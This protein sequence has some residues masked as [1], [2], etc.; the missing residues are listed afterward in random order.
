MSTGVPVH[1]D[2][3]TV[4]QDLKLGKKYAYVIYKLNETYTEIVVE[5]TAPAGAKYDEFVASLPATDCRYCVYDVEYE[6]AEGGVRNK[7][8]FVAWSPDDARIKAKMTYAGSK[9]AIR[10]KLVGISTEVQATDFSEIDM[11]A[12]LDKIQRI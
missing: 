10:R 1:D 11:S 7:I 6:A 2:C 9:D 4:F 5:K 8:I 12:I 3:L